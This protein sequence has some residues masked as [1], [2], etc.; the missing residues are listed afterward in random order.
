LPLRVT[1]LDAGN[2]G[3]YTGAGNHTYLVAGRAPLLIDAGVGEP[4]HLDEVGAALGGGTLARVVVTHNHPDHIKGIAAIAARWPGAVLLKKPWP[5]QDVKYPV[6]W[7]PLADGDEVPAGDGRLRVI[8]TPGHA[9]DHLCLLDED[10]RTLFAGDLLM[11]DGTVVIPPT[12]GGSLARYLAS[13][14]RV[15]ALAPARALAAHGPEIDD[16]VALARRY[17]EHRR[18]RETQIVRALGHGAADLEALL[19]RVYVGLRPEVEGAARESVLAHLIKLEEE[20]RAERDER[21]RW[22]LA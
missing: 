16:P 18:K 2:P 12:Y 20:G 3:P 4:R 14:E 7:S 21:G 10:S 17:L 15:V 1:V 19:P 6:S 22:R 8:G 13:L 11:R 9:P 5:E